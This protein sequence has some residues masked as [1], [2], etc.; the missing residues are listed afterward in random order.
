MTLGCVLPVFISHGFIS[1]FL[2]HMV[3][4]IYIFVQRH[5]HDD[6]CFHYP[7]PPPVWRCRAWTTSC[8]VMHIACVVVRGPML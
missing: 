3:L 2:M 4:Y 8:N 5:M 7:P 1:I 6:E